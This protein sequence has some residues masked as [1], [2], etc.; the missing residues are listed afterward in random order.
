MSV[1]P[2]RCEAMYKQRHSLSGRCHF[3]ANVKHLKW[4]K[5]GCARAVSLCVCVCVCVCACVC[6]CVCV[7]LCVSISRPLLTY[8]FC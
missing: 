4:G 5:L 6:V 7:C 3:L 2:R 8:L 1:E